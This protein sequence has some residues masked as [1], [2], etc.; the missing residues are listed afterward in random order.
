LNPAVVAAVAGL[1]HV[2]L[3]AENMT[4]HREKEIVRMKR[5]STG[6][7]L[8]ALASLLGLACWISLPLAASREEKPKAKRFDQRL[9]DEL[10]KRKARF[11]PPKVAS[12]RTGQRVV[13][14]TLTV[15]MTIHEIDVD[16]EAAGKLKDRVRTRSYNGGLCGPVIRVRPGDQLKIHLKNDIKRSEPDTP[17][18]PNNPTAPHGFNVTN[19]HTHGLNVSPSGRSDNVFLEVAPEES[20]DLCFDIPEDHP[21]GTFWY[22]AHKHGSV[23]MQLAGGMAGVLIVEKED[24]KGSLDENPEVALATKDHEKILVFQLIPYRPAGEGQ[25]ADVLKDD[26]YAAPKT[27]AALAKDDKLVRNT[28]I[29]GELF[30]T[31]SM[32]PGEVQRWRCVHGGLEQSLDLVLVKEGDSADD[33][34][35]RVKLYEIAVDGLPLG[36]RKD[37]SH[38][39]LQPGYRSDLLVQAPPPGSYLLQSLEMPAARS[40]GNIKQNP[41]YLARVKVEGAQMQPKM[42]LPKPEDLKAYRLPSVKNAV[43]RPGAI[44]FFSDESVKDFQINGKVFGQDE[45][46]LSVKLDD[47]EEWSLESQGG[48]HPFHIHVN[49]FEVIRKDEDGNAERVWRDTLLVTPGQV[50]IWTQFK[51]FSGMTVLHCHNLR[52]EDQGMM[53]A[54]E[55]KGKAPKPS[56]PPPPSAGFGKLPAAAPAW[57]LPE[58]ANQKPARSSDV[59]FK[60]K[61]LLLVFSRGAECVHCR[62]QVQALAQG[63]KLLEAGL[64]VVIVCPVPPD[65]LPTKEGFTFL[66]DE[67]WVAFKDYHCHDGRALHGTFLIDTK[68]MIQWQ[69]AGDVPFTD[70][71]ALVKE[72]AKL[73]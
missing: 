53:A 28:L 20:M 8:L 3:G 51:K 54:F 1:R 40:I 63:N 5:L 33:K 69:D 32:R 47:A 16:V 19:L 71:A 37:W 68:G 12:A 38:V 22:H 24:G 29:N 73:K 55:I 9:K 66:A 10:A 17:F 2:D 45:L 60:G 62:A 31:I 46:L 59:K 13:E 49:P 56:C 26:V 70:V 52:H 43:K 30:P 4:I 44:S 27:K 57:E 48:N 58:K 65:K 21:C 42:E 18:D 67:S 36:T 15:A 35:K 14:V 41:R 61:K 6:L 25:V 34:D 64:T 23:A 7:R 39:E 72:A 50:T 11:V